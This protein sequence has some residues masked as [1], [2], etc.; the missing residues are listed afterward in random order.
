MRNGGATALAEMLKKNVTITSID[1]RSN[2]IGID[3][4]STLFQALEE[5]NKTLT[6]IDLSGMSGINLPC[7]LHRELM[8]STKESTGIT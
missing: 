2:D 8:S 6:S 1:L 3:G 5:D 7:K 4:G